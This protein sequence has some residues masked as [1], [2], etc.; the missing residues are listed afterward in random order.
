ML[1]PD[2]KDKILIAQ[3]NEITEYVVYKQLARLVRNK[4]HADI[5]E[6]VSREEL[7]HY[8]Y[9]HKLSGQDVRPDRC[10]G[11]FYVVISRF[12]GLN[13]GLKLM[14]RGE[15]LAQDVYERLSAAGAGISDIMKDEKQH[16]RELL[17]LI[18]EDRLKYVSS[19]IL[20]LNDAL[21]ELTATV[22]G[23]TLALQNTKLI[24][25]VGLITGIAAAMSM[26]ASEYLA[27]KHEPEDKEPLK[28]GLYTGLSYI[29]VV[30][31]LVSPYFL[32]GNIFL[33]LSLT[34]LLALL[35]ILIFTY[36]ISIA[37]GHPFKE[38]F[39]EMAVLSLVIAAITF[40]IGLAVRHV[41]GVS[42]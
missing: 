33:C 17:D 24:G 13:F 2:L 34:I 19:V 29:V 18:D 9:F 31:I 22:A 23:F 25:V 10:K 39:V 4:A 41:F 6:R 5:L 16:E 1:T 15:H 8:N 30:L 36:Y 7:G 42:I 35:A 27:T 20:G 28:A 11:F 38:R 26:G 3:K 14:E 37:Q 21:V 12:F 32:L 40:L